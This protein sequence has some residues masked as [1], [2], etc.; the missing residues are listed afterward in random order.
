MNY[1]RRVFTGALASFIVLVSYT[2][3]LKLP[4]QINPDFL[5]AT[6][7]GAL[8]CCLLAALA[9]ALIVRKQVAVLVVSTQVV[10][11]LIIG[12]IWHL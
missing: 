9:V 12:L 2:V 5:L 1:M 3:A 7:F 11:I 6:F 10:S 8:V 4:S